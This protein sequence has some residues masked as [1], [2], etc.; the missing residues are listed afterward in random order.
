MTLALIMRINLVFNGVSTRSWLYS[1]KQKYPG[2]SNCKWKKL[3]VVSL[4]HF[5]R[6]QCIKDVNKIMKIN[7]SN[8]SVLWKTIENSNYKDSSDGKWG[9]NGHTIEEVVNHQD[10]VTDTYWR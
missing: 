8:A 4:K 10:Q 3:P 9:G 6:G 5:K 2:K 7:F 1:G